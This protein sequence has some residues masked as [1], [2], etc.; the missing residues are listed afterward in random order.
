MIKLVYCLMSLHKIMELNV[1]TVKKIVSSQFP[2]YANLE[3]SM[4]YKSG[5]DNRTFHLGNE[6]S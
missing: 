3:I 6:F 4:V 5:H 2:H 1:Q